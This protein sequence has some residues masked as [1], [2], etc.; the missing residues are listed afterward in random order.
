LLF[1]ILHSTPQIPSKIGHPDSQGTGFQSHR[2]YQVCGATEG[3][4]PRN[5]GGAD[6]VV[7]AG[8]GIDAA[9]GGLLH[10]QAGVVLSVGLFAAEPSKDQGCGDT[11]KWRVQSSFTKAG[12]RQ[13]Y[14]SAKQNNYD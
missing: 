6:R 10:T 4:Q 12:V 14:F 11:Q 8:G 5:G 2:D 13:R 1:L 3:R 7:S 9:I